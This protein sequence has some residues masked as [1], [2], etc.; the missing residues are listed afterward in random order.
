MT[1]NYSPIPFLIAED[2]PDDRQLIKDAFEEA[3]ILNKLYFVSDGEELLAFLRQEGE[4][5]DPHL[6]PRPGL[7]LL[8]LNMPK[9]DGR[10]ALRLI[11]TDDNFKSIPLVVITTSRADSDIQNSYASGANSFITKPHSF[12]SLVEMV[13]ML[14]K[15]WLQVVEL[16]LS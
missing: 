4:F 15:Y 14:N 6:A 12:K 10:E 9:I 7:I 2:D 16:P 1:H 3:N 8:D 13:K 11:K 5:S